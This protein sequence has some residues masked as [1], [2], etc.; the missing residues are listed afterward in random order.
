MLIRPALNVVSIALLL[1]SVH[2]AAL[3]ADKAG[4]IIYELKAG[5]LA[6]DVDGLWSG[7][8]YENGLDINLEAT[9]TPAANILGGTLRPGFGTTINTVGDT[10]KLYAYGRWEYEFEAGF[11]FALGLGAA[12]HD[13]EL[14]VVS[15]DRKALGSRVLFHIPI[16]VGYRFDGHNG[17]SVYFDHMSNAYL[18]HENEGMDTL[19]GR[20][21][22][23]F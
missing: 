14:H 7:H 22:Y 10:S 1:A 11:Y 2:G 4:G 8:R 20:Y 19:G 12:V 18:A 5:L 9:F 16:E 6:H 15:P 23:R 13:G 17:I 3:A 21:G